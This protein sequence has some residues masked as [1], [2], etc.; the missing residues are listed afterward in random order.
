MFGKTPM[1]DKKMNELL[2]S[3]R[4]LKNH[5]EH[6]GIFSRFLG[7]DS[8]YVYSNDDLQFYFQVN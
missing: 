4:R 3:A 2:V 5:N 7:L 6:I 1:L 8:S